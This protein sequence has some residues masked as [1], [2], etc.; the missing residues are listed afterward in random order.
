M[1]KPVKNFLAGFIEW[2]QSLPTALAGQVYEV[3]VMGNVGP[4]QLLKFVA[5]QTRM[6]EKT[7]HIPFIGLAHSEDLLV[8]PVIEHPH[9]RRVLIE[10]LNFQAGIWQIVIF[11]QPAAEAFQ[12]GKMCVGGSVDIFFQN[13]LDITFDVLGLEVG[14]INRGKGDKSFDDHFIMDLCARFMTPIIAEPSG[15]CLLEEHPCPPL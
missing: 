7:D 11:G 14:G 13:M 3:P 9:L 10:H 15:G 12:G 5:A 4:G 6:K 2:Y 1:G 8:F